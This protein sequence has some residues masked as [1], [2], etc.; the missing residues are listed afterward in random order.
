MKDVDNLEHR[1]R[2]LHRRQRELGYETQV[3]SDRLSA[4]VGALGATTRETSAVVANL[5]RAGDTNDEIARERADRARSERDQRVLARAGVAFASSLDHDATVSRIAELV[6]RELADFCIVDLVDHDRQV[7]RVK[8]ASR[9]ERRDWVCDL[10]QQV[11]LDRARPYLL[12]RAL[13]LQQ[14]ILRARL[15]TE[16][17]GALSQHDQHLRALQAANPRSVIAVPLVARGTSIG[18][19]GLLSSAAIYDPSDVLLA[20]ELAHRAALAIDNARQYQQARQAIRTRDD[21][22]GIVAHD[23][24]T[25]L[26]AIALYAEVLRAGPTETRHTGDLI[27]RNAA[28]MRRLIEDLLDVA[29][30]D[31]GRLSLAR[32]T[33]PTTELVDE[34]AQAQRPLCEAAGLELRVDLAPD[35]PDVDADRDRL[36]Q[37]F[38]NLVGNAVKFTPR[39][40]CITIGASTHDQ[41]TVFRVSDTGVGIPPE[42]QHHLFDRYWQ[43]RETR[44]LG[45]GLGLS[46]AKGLVE[47]HG[48]RIWVDSVAGRGSTF[49]FTIPAARSPGD[50]YP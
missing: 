9:D 43:A 28:R 21:I 26:N 49:H 25:P 46:I 32:T 44:R 3:V 10:L 8:V 34:V 1:V 24:R 39:A 33:F 11:E 4:V 35:V 40:G 48:G 16:A 20:E 38:E 23:L 31:G 12:D 5:G 13:E 30:L 27:A 42:H 36:R 22:L 45:V 41:D 18:V 47:A 37:V 15:T 14:P 29:S 50:R 6:V 19:I 17:L 7:R 2:G